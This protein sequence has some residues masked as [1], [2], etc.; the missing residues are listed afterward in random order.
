[1]QLAGARKLLVGPHGKAAPAWT[2][3]YSLGSTLANTTGK[4]ATSTTP[5][6]CL[7]RSLLL[8]KIHTSPLL[9]AQTR[10]YG[11]LSRRHIA[12]GSTLTGAARPPLNELAGRRFL[13]ALTMRHYVPSRPFR[14]LF[15]GKVL[16]ALLSGITHILRASLRLPVM[17][18]T[19]TIAS[20]AYV[21]YKLSQMHAPGWITGSLE[22]ARGWLEGIR[23]SAWLRA[24]SSDDREEEDS[25]AVDKAMGMRD[26]WGGGGSGGSGGSDPA[27]GGNPQPPPPKG[28]YYTSPEPESLRDDVPEPVSRPRNRAKTSRRD[29]SSENALME[30]TKKLLEIQTILKTV[31]QSDDDGRNG[32]SSALQ[33]PSIVVVGSQ[34]SG[35]SS[36]LEAIVG[37][38]FL[39]KGNNMVTRRPI[40]LTLI[41]TP[42]SDEEYG[43]FP[44]LGM[45]HVGDFRQIQRTLYDLNMSVSD[46]ECVSDK[47][48]E[49]RIYSPHV[50]DLRLVDLPG[51][52]QVV[53]RKQPPELRQK[54]RDLCEGYLKQPNIILAVCAADVDLANSEALKASRRNDPLGM[55]TIGVITKIDT[56]APAAATS[57]LTQNDYPL[58][59]G[60]IGVVC[61]PVRETPGRDVM[62]SEA[63]YF[64]RHPEFRQPGLQVG[65][66]TLRRKLVRVLE[67]SMRRS[68]SNLTDAVRSELEETKY[69]IKVHYND[70]RVSPESY[71]AESLD[72]LKQR[73]KTFQTQFGKPQ[74]R[75]EVQH[76]LESRVMDVCAELYWSDPAVVA[77]STRVTRSRAAGWWADIR[78]RAAQAAQAATGVISELLAADTAKDQRGPR[79]GG[80]STSIGGESAGGSRGGTSGHQGA[81][82]V[83]REWS[84]VDDA[85]WDH[86]LDRAAALLTKSGVG[87]WTTQLV[88][89][90]LMDN[91]TSM[92]DAEP[93]IH[94]PDTRTAVLNFSH[95]ILRSKYHST[96]DQVEN[97]IKPFKYEVE[98]EPHE[99]KKAQKRS[100]TLVDNEIRLCRQALVKLRTNVPRKQLQQAIQL[101]RAAEKRGIDP[102]SI[103]AELI[104]RNGEQAAET[105]GT[106]NAEHEGAALEPQTTPDELSYAQHSP[107]M[108]RRAQQVL[109]IQDRLNILH[110]RRKALASTSC[111]SP[112]NKRLCPE[113]FL[114]VVAEKLSYNAVLFINYELLQDF[115]FQFPRELDSNLYYGKTLQQTREFASQNP[116][117]GKQL[118]LLERRQKLEVV[119]TRLQELMRQQAQQA[120]SEPYGRQGSGVR[121]GL[122]EQSS[123]R[124]TFPGL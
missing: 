97:T 82:P 117:V 118:Q 96:V 12:L 86:Q 36:V 74:L 31:Q 38:E 94:H 69:Q 90:L 39:P 28:D 18:L 26:S 77:L 67:D 57:I 11:P 10:E 47:P 40:E 104:R 22:S 43:A 102:V 91:V 42:D 14:K 5:F 20:L 107:R 95:A 37:Q 41:N 100:G 70:E 120:S 27:S 29:D 16:L 45:D 17:L 2:R 25:S 61:R 66:G 75:T 46:A 6:T 93:F 55:R 80:K 124:R 13:A 101:A 84:D 76:W 63:Q 103:H 123:Y 112:D 3:A 48:I 59:L 121:A 111:A 49:L 51:Y 32:S 23:E 110:M 106:G 33:L 24:L 99:W 1:M 53:N 73:F 30:L 62:L 15:S 58:H 68:L 34:S 109:M 122:P 72:A 113:I 105:E 87:R 92:V 44:Q 60:Y 98:V 7:R 50:P 116:R 8:K 108:L 21:E 35:K 81:T 88:V 4:Q 52:I 78:T 64:G 54:I 89:D 83:A 85:Y 9:R 115:F 19:S 56:T 114:D 71:M 79:L 65:V 119:M